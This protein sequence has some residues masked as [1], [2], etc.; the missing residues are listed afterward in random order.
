MWSLVDRFTAIAT[1][2]RERFEIED[3]GEEA[4]EG[5]GAGE[6]WGEEGEEDEDEPFA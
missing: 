5:G 4:D 1:A 2:L 3:E 6:E